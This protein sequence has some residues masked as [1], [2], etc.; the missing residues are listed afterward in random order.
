MLEVVDS[1]FHIWDLN[2]LNLPWLN[3]CAGV[4][5]RSFSVDD[6]V[7]EYG[8]HDLTFKGGVYVEVD[9]D[10][11]IREDDY[12]FNL[13]SPY[14]LSRIMRARHLCAHM[15]LPIGIAGVREPLH[16]DSS[17]RG[18]CLEKSFVEGL[19]V[20]AEKDMVFESCNRVDELEDFYNSVSL[21]PEAKVVINHCGNVQ[22]LNEDYKRAMRKLGSLPNVYCKVSGFPTEDKAFVKDLLDFITDSFD[23]SRLLYA[24]N[25]PVCNLYSTFDDHLNA[26]REYFQDDPDV[27]AKNT[28]K[29]YKINK[30]Q[31]FASVIKLRPEKAAYYKQ[32]HADPFSSVNKMIRECGITKYQIFNRDDLLFSVMEYCG[33]DFDYDMAKMAQDPETQRWWK[34]T[35]PCQTRIDGAYKDEWW[36]NMELVYDLNKK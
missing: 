22:D 27:F 3:S 6:L 26:V 10:D 33:D 11:A 23:H 24:S 19:Q 15:R 17:P 13:H 29:L 8:R 12:I 25:Y 32:L 21:V 5:K 14:I 16:I 4:I 1:H 35:D 28:K 18:R 2:V 7:K 34:E 20:L 30:P 9:C 36:A 31:I